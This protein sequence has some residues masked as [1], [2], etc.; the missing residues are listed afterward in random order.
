MRVADTPISLEEEEEYKE[1][2]PNSPT[3]IK[4]FLTE[5]IQLIKNLL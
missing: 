2:E 5:L 1:K 3:K 4:D